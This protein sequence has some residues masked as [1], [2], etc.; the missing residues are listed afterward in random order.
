M[1]LGESYVDTSW[2]RSAILLENYH[3]VY[4]DMKI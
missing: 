1:S 3:G 2:R 4:G